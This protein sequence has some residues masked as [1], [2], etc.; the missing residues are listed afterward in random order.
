MCIVGDITFVVLS[1][2]PSQVQVK[3]LGAGGRLMSSCFNLLM[4]MRP[5]TMELEQSV[6]QPNFMFVKSTFV[7]TLV[8]RV[9]LKS[10]GQG[11]AF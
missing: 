3:E 4:V 7:F 2:N 11:W 8:P 10:L 1:A 9:C 6:L 5:R